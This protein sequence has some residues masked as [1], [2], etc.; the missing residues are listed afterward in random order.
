MSSETSPLLTDL[1][2]LNMLQAYLEHGKTDLAVFEFFVR[3][4]P[5]QRGFLVAA[6][7]ETALNFLEEFHFQPAEI[8][9]LQSTGRFGKD[10][11]GFLSRMRFTGDVHAMAEGTIFFENEPILRV[12]APLPQA[13]LVETR[14]INILNFQSMIVSKAARLRLIAPD[15]QLVDFGL[16]RAH[17]AEAGLMAARA[18]Y[19]GGFDGTATLLANQQFGIP[20][21]GTMAHSF[22]EV[23]DRES[24]AFEAFARSRPTDLV[25]LIDTYNTLEATEKVVTMAPRL[26]QEGIT[27]KGV[28]IDSGD[29]VQLS[30]AV[31]KILDEGGLEEIRIIVSG[32]LDEPEVE[33]LVRQKAPVDV[34]GIGTS[35]VTSMDVPA[36]DC[37]YKLQEYEGMARRKRSSG[38]ATWPGAKQVWRQYDHTDS[39]S[40][41]YLSLAADHRPGTALIQP[42]MQN[43]RR[44]GASSL[45]SAK[46]RAARDVSQLP[47][48]LRSRQDGW[49]Y[50]V[51]VSSQLRDLAN[52]ID[53]RLQHGGD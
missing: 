44:L 37:A 19:I 39:M 5:K 20:V 51:T 48:P 4:L 26:Q 15:Q 24:A 33:E 6:G 42:V 11:L 50:P 25:F 7:L 23:F 8:A 16:R 40:G 45:A 34:L 22:V 29:L 28:R 18:S 27:V 9:W 35:L 32:G 49:A 43:G 17:G 53:Q 12:T 47:A 14:L 13:Q 21:H 41:D 52:Q 2:Q 38:K 46:E 1:Y 36:L 31:R 3:R 30:R 10:F